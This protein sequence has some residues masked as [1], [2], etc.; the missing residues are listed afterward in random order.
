[1]FQP[2]A[3]RVPA[4]SSRDGGL[5][6]A[7]P[8][9][10]AGLCHALRQ[11]GTLD[12][13]T[14]LA[15]AIRLAEQGFEADA[16]WRAAARLTRQELDERATRTG[17]ASE[18]ATLRDLYLTP[19]G[20]DPAT[21][22]FESRLAPALR[23]I[24]A[25]GPDGFYR[26]AVAASLVETVRRHGGLLTMA[27]LESYPQLVHEREAITGDWREGQVVSMPPPSS[28]GI[29]IVESLN[30]LSELDRRPGLRPLAE[31]PHESPEYAHRVIEALQHAFA[32][33]A[34]YLGDADHVDVPVAELTSRDH[35]A[36]LA[37]R[38]DPQRTLPL[39]AYGKIALGDDGGTSHLSIIDAAGNAVACTETINTRFGS[40]VVDPEFG[41][42]LN[43]EMDDFTAVPGAPNAFGLVQSELNSV[44]PG[45]KP[46]SSMSPTIL[47]RDGQAVAVVG[48]SGGPRII[49]GTLQTLLNLTLHG[50]SPAEAVARP[51]FHHQ[52]LP[53]VVLLETG[54]EPQVGA[55]LESRGHLVERTSGVGNVQAVQRRDDGLF[56]ASDPRKGGRPAGW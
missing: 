8:G 2:A 28:G 50:D 38:F 15:P 33:R 37:A 34:A 3:D 39:S 45:K 19:A 55:G 29:A 12:L 26:G 6:V 14:V 27:D 44:A 22:R 9:T 51:R 23:R 13:P 30:I 5:A 53:Q 48:A 10:V 41:I 24:A 18:F 42:V 49:T 32:D 25:A 52:W 47:L 4:P 20:S 11:Y 36:K 56:G 7:V 21:P 43:N 40:L 31:L 35:A 16:H 17:N 54:F 46:L 1:M